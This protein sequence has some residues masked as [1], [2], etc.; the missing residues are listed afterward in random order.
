MKI[1]N[2]P[3]NKIKKDPNQPRQYFTQQ[4]VDEM[5]IS[6]KNEG[7]INPIEI[8]KKNIIITGEMRWRATKKA[9][10]KTIPCKI[11]EISPNKR[12]IRQM[13]ENIHHHTMTAWDT[14]KG[15]EKTANILRLSPGDNRDKVHSHPTKYVV[16]LSKLYGLSHNTISEYLDLLEESERVRRAIRK[17]RFPYTKIRESNKAPKKYVD[18][19]KAKVIKEKYISRE[20]I[21]AISAGLRRAEAFGNPEMIKKLM[22]NNYKDKKGNPMTSREIILKVNKIIPDTQTILE[23]DIDRVKVITKKITELGN[24]LEKNPLSSIKEPMSR[25]SL[26]AQLKILILMVDKYLHS[27]SF[28]RQL[29]EAKSQE[30]KLLENKS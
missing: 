29:G 20:G 18:K 10:L 21:S 14:A 7:V 6:I 26:M 2:V 22:E 12:F 25:A 19:L 17:N 8:D 1:I 30:V 11:L 23:K 28:T 15:F 24:Y 4:A 27:Q 5:A 3:I 9:G 16:E 13:Q